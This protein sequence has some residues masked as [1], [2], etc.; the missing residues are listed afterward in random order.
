MCGFPAK[1][2]QSISIVTTKRPTLTLPAPL[3]EI[4]VVLGCQSCAAAL[5]L[6]PAK[7]ATGGRPGWLR[8]KENEA[9]VKLRELGSS[10]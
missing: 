1:H 3:A 7:E 10:C 9:I 2:L 8:Y 5:E 4:V 6:P